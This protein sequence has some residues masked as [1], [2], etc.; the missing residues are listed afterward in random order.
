MEM[1]R[2]D[3]DGNLRERFEY[4]D[5]SFPLGVWIDDYG[6]KDNK[7]LEC[8]W[9]SDIEVGVLLS[10][11]LEFNL[12]G[13]KI[14]LKE[15]DGI[16]INPDTLHTATSVNPDK[17]A[18]M[19]VISF[20][21]EIFT[22]SRYTSL[23]EKYFKNIVTGGITG[24]RIDPSR[25]SGKMAIEAMKELYLFWLEKEKLML[26][27]LSSLCKIWHYTTEYVSLYAE[28]KVSKP[29]SSRYGGEMKLMIYYIQ[30]HCSENISVDDLAQYAGI[31][32]SECFRCFK[33]LAGKT[34]VTYIN[35]YRLA[36]AAKLLSSTDMTVTSICTECGFSDP[37]YFCRLFK[38]SYGVSPLSY[39][40]KK[41]QPIIG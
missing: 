34:P 19:A 27:C 37:S 25:E 38:A 17:D 7:T 28:E 5:P 36:Y 29:I 9:H 26:L 41:S 2:I 8:H 35:E 24:C 15:G 20:R 14:L 30:N 3:A 23:Y 4:P 22:K 39:R 16:F 13:E 11:E 32:R 10:G 40:K 33:R 21:P 31:S 1:Q 18:A 12:A 6:L